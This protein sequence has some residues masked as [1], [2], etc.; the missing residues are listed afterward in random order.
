MEFAKSKDKVELTEE[1]VSIID[2]YCKNNM[3]RLKRVCFPLINKKKDVSQKDV[4]DLLSEAMGA[5][6]T[7]VVTFKKDQNIKFSTYLQRSISYA[8]YDWS[9]ENRRQMRCNVIKDNQGKPVIIED[10]SLDAKINEEE[11]SYEFGEIV[12]SGFDVFKCL[13]HETINDWHSETKEFLK[14]L[15]PLQY[16]IAILISENYTEDEICEVLH[17]TKKHYKNLFKRIVSDESISCLKELV[18]K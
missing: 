1:Q 11:K 5:L 15:T 3:S 13:C 14:N 7:S 17:I 9:R 10:L 4:D 16:K 8:L 18:S 6:F 12:D 2:Y